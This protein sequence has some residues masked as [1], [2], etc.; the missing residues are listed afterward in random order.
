MALLKCLNNDVGSKNEDSDYVDM[1]RVIAGTTYTAGN[2]GTTYTAPINNG[3][4]FVSP[5]ELCDLT[6][7]TVHKDDIDISHMNYVPAWKVMGEENCARVPFTTPNTSWIFVDPVDNTIGVTCLNRAE[8]KM[9][10]QWYHCVM[11]MIRIL[12]P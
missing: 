12:M 4:T 6:D 7:M 10:H 8:T 3:F 1:S 9:G 11:L 5:Y 2:A